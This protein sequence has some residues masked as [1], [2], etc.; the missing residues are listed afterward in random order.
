MKLK[1]FKPVKY[2]NHNTARKNH[3][4]CVFDSIEKKATLQCNN[5]NNNNQFLNNNHSSISLKFVLLCPC[6][7]RS[8]FLLF[9]VTEKETIILKCFALNLVCL[10]VLWEKRNETKNHAKRRKKILLVAATAL[11]KLLS[12][13]ISRRRRRSKQQ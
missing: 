12:K 5:N 9:F 8:N 6:I 10:C 11:I 2:L 1:I 13:K 7:K 4:H 3:Y